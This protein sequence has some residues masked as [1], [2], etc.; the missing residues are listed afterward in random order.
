[1]FV[2]VVVVF[3]GGRSFINIF[4]LVLIF[5]WLVFTCL[6]LC[7]NVLFTFLVFSKLFFLSLSLCTFDCTI[8]GHLYAVEIFYHFAH[9]VKCR[10]ICNCF[11]I[12]LLVSL[13]TRT[14]NALTWTAFVSDG[15]TEQALDR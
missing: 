15:R 5:G 9:V 7:L 3:F 13:G 6:S 12:T 8:F 1:M 10:N 2:V 11:L 4:H 14:V